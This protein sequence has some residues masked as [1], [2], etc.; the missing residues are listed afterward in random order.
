MEN[1]LFLAPHFPLFPPI[2]LLE[3][4]G[5]IPCTPEHPGV[6]EVGTHLF[7]EAGTAPGRDTQGRKTEARKMGGYLLPP[8]LPLPCASHM[9]Y[10]YPAKPTGSWG[11]GGL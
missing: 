4:L 3:A 5:L 1:G 8:P 7:P 6:R 2:F 10:P 11:V 9:T